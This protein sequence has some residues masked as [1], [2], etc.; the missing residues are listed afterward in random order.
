MINFCHTPLRLIRTTVAAL[1]VGHATSFAETAFAKAMAVSPEPINLDTVS[2]REWPLRAR[3]IG[4]RRTPGH[5]RDETLWRRR[6]LYWPYYTT[7]AARGSRGGEIN[8]LALR[9]GAAGGAGRQ[10]DRKSTR[11]E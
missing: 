7:R 2:R 10:T 6:A 5:T 11:L 8:F 9:G 1:H 4:R 3:E